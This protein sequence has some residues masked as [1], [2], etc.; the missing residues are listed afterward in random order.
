MEANF[1][2]FVEKFK[3]NKDAFLIIL[4][5]DGLGWLAKALKDLCTG[6]SDRVLLGDGKP[7]SSDSKLFLTITT[8][9]KPSSSGLLSL[10][11][12][13]ILL[14][15]SKLEHILGLLDGLATNARGH[16]YFDLDPKLQIVFSVAEYS[17]DRLRLMRKD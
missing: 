7:V 13:S 16:Q 15:V 14:S 6:L 10:N 9:A 2:A 3:G 17:A 5:A 11:N 1:V 8:N 4:D 12:P